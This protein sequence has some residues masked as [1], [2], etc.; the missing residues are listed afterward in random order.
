MDLAEAQRSFYENQLN[1]REEVIDKSKK[2]CFVFFSGHGVFRPYTISGFTKMIVRDDY[3]EWQNVARSPYIKK[4]AGLILFIRDIYMQFYVEGINRNINS[5]DALV[6]FVKSKTK[7]Y[8]VICCGSS[9]GG[10]IAALVG[11]KIHCRFVLSKS[12]QFSLYSWGGVERK[13]LLKKHLDEKRYNRY[14]DI[15]SLIKKSKVPIFYFYAYMNEHDLQQYNEISRCGN[16]FCFA[17]QSDEHAVTCRGEDFPLILS[18][19]VRTLKKLCRKCKGKVLS[20]TGFEVKLMGVHG[21][22]WQKFYSLFR[23]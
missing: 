16:V 3:Y 9:A 15:V 7:G 8:D 10:Y 19:D 23:F 13:P 12:G 21:F 18:K 4:K 11:S 1:Y 20:Q 22:L 6:E 5:V 17:F 14:Y 2:I